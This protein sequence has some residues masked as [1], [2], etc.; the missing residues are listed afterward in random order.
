MS[1]LSLSKILMPV[2]FSAKA[3]EAVQYA[4]HL[5]KHFHAEMVLLHVLEPPHLDYAMVELTESIE[6][7]T[8]ARCENAKTRLE[9][10]ASSDF[11]GIK[12]VRTIAQGQP[13]EEI[14]AHAEGVDLVVM[15][16]Q[17]HGRIREFLI[18]SVTAKVLHDCQR[19]VLTGVH[20]TAK[21]DLPD[22][23]V[24]N[25]LCAVDFDPQ[26][27]TVLKWGAQMKSEFG[28][29]VTVV[30]ADADANTGQ[31]LREC[32]Q[33]A[34][35]EANAVIEAGEPNKVVVGTAERIGADLVIIARGSSTGAL[36]RLR[37]QAYEIVRKSPCPVLSV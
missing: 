1:T 18:G 35:L 2:D 29:A 36:G 14:I 6:R 3:D 17:G 12:L 15:P 19:P 27:E 13:A 22:W 30:H 32:I 8:R 33:A 9:H 23:Q 5:A 20:L 34:G 4:S 28:A 21:R 26:C 11:E 10:F 25:I 24:S 7:L 16:T 31:R 37:A